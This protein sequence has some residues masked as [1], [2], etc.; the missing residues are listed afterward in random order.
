MKCA[1][2]AAAKKSRMRTTESQILVSFV[3]KL[4]GETKWRISSFQDGHSCPQFHP[5]TSQTMEEKI[6]KT[7]ICSCCVLLEKEE[8][9][10]KPYVV[11]LDR[12][13]ENQSLE[14]DARNTKEKA[15]IQ[16]YNNF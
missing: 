15:M 1:A 13:L 6:N 11:V 8:S 3:S 4:C 2:A 14:W 10:G 16:L 5:L 9:G 7:H 12:S